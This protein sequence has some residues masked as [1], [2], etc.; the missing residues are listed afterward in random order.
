MLQPAAR[1]I[2]ASA[3]RN[4]K[5]KRAASRLPIAVL[6]API[7][8]TKT[9]DRPSRAGGKEA[10]SAA[11]NSVLRVM[12]ADGSTPADPPAKPPAAEWGWAMRRVFLFLVLAGLLVIL[13]GGLALG[14][15]PPRPHPQPVQ[16]VIPNDKLTPREQG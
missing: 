13:A 16:H 6:P 12:A 11:A 1:S 5:P 10:W 2:S 4:G 8:P 15:F 7:S 14:L 9:T 3:S